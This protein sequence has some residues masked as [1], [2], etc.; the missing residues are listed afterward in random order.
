[1]RRIDWPVSWSNGCISSLWFALGQMS[2]LK[3]SRKPRGRTGHA[4]RS[5]DGVVKDHWLGSICSARA[6][7]T[8]K[9]VQ[10]CPVSLSLASG[11]RP[12]MAVSWWQSPKISFQISSKKEKKWYLFLSLPW[13]PYI[14]DACLCNR[15]WKCTR[16]CIGSAS[17]CTTRWIESQHMCLH[18]HR[19]RSSVGAGIFPIILSKS[20]EESSVLKYFPIP[21]L[22][23][24]LDS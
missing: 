18:H 4:Q 11:M 13:K 8:D 12:V 6:E 17:I 23:E 7:W 19:S 1:M 21:S 3:K 20:T 24:L 22:Q 10:L 14:S 16:L 15:F 9:G 2:V 5:S